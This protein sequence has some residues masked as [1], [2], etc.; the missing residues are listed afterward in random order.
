MFRS[1]L[2][3]VSSVEHSEHA[4]VTGLEFAQREGA[5]VELVHAM[6]VPLAHWPRSDPAQLARALAGERAR[7]EA[8]LR[9]MLARRGGNVGKLEVREL[10]HVFSGSAAQVLLDRAVAV[11]ADLLVLGPHGKRLLFDFGDT[12][13]AVLAKATCAVLVQPAHFRPF[14]RIL[15]P[16]DLSED[17]LYALGRAVQLA[18]ER[19]ARIDTLHCFTLPDLN[20]AMGMGHPVAEPARVVEQVREGTRQEFERALSGMD[21]QGVQHVDH[22]VEGAPAPA[23]QDLQHEVD[24]IVMGSHGRTGLAAAVLGSVAYSVLKHAEVPVLAMR[25]PDRRWLTQ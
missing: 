11:G 1:I 25:V 8:E 2:V 10:L 12:A 20:N 16:I 7:L 6:P 5:R 4:I 22:F 18:R 21:W 14:R 13:R 3:G 19:G 23:I 17:S 9:G 24:L 15:V